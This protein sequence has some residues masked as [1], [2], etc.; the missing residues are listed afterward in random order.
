MAIIAMDNTNIRVPWIHTRGGRSCHTRGVWPWSH[1]RGERP[2]HT[3]GVWPWSHTRGE[4][5]CHTRGVWPW[6]HTREVWPWSHTRG[7]RP[8]HTREV[9]PWSHTREV[10][11]LVLILSTLFWNC[12]IWIN[13][14]INK[15][16]QSGNIDYWENVTIRTNS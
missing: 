12:N 13:E 2:C 6:S 10:R 14:H 1:T 5:P 15:P 9:W 11:L 7:E 3:R 16:C 4:R 8:C